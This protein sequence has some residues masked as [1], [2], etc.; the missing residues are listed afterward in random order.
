[1]SVLLGTRAAVSRLPG[2]YNLPCSLVK[3]TASV[4]SDHSNVRSDCMTMRSDFMTMRSDHIIV[5]GYKSDL[6]LSHLYPETSGRVPDVREVAG[7]KERGDSFS[8][9]IPMDEV[10]IAREGTRVEIRWG[11]TE[12]F[13]ITV[14]SCSGRFHVESASWLS[15]ATKASIRSHLGRE[16]SREGWLEVMSNRYNR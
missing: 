5:R 13:V 11:I 10:S 3:M 1:M 16:L 7:E 9:F 15:E 4:R 6:S 2:K 8:G 14:T 12:K